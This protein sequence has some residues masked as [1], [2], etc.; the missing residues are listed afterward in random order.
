LRPVNLAIALPRIARSKLGPKQA[1]DLLFLQFFVAAQGECAMKFRH[2]SL[3]L[4]V[5]LSL[6]A[7]GGGTKLVKHPAP[8]PT[9]AALSE[10]SDQRI[11]AS[12]DWV[13]V[14]DGPGTWAKNADWDEYLIR[15][16]NASPE[17]VRITG[18]AVFDSLGTRIEPRSDRKQLVKGSKQSVKRYRDSGLEVKAGMGGAGLVAAGAAA[19]IAGYGVAIGT[20]SSALLSGGTTAA[21]GVAAASVLIL[22]APV[23]A[24]FGVVRAVHNSEVNSEIELRHAVLPTDLPTAQTVSLHIF[25]PL[26]PSPRHVELAY[27]DAEGQ[28]LLEIDTGTALAGLHL[29]HRGIEPTSDAPVAANR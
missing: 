10:A 5:A 16:V 23:F 17:P 3:F 25:F 2:P 18:V 22:A 8:A 15:V 7:C 21:G 14:R 4:A 6:C 24:V 13:I 27:E 20:A 9:Q 11:S 1:P 29:Q 19:G 12:L 26:A 28:H